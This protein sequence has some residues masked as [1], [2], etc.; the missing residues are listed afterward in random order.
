MILRFIFAIM[1][2][3][4]F[5]LF[6]HYLFRKTFTNETTIKNMIE[7]NNNI[8]DSIYINE[9]T[10]TANFYIADIFKNDYNYT[11]YELTYSRYNNFKT[12]LE[13]DFYN[14]NYDNVII[15]C[16]KNTNY[17]NY[18]YYLV[19]LIIMFNIYTTFKDALVNQSFKL[20]NVSNDIIIKNN[21]L[22]KFDDVI[23]LQT[24]KDDLKQYVD[25]IHNR[26]IY[27]Q[28]GCKIPRGLLFSGPPGTGK[29]LLAKALAGESN[30]T[31]IPVS[32]SDFIEMYVGVGSA[33]IKKLFEVARQNAPSIIFID[34]IDTIGQ[35]RK[36]H[37]T[38]N[39]QGNTLNKLLTE[40]DGFE[41]DDNVFIIAATNIIDQLDPA[42]TRS[43]RFDRKII[44]DKPNKDERAQMF[45]L[46]LNKVSKHSQFQKNIINNII[47]LSEMT[48]GL[49]GADIS[50]IINLAS[51]RSV[52]RITN[53]ISE[54]QDS[55]DQED[56]DSEDQDSEDQE[57]QDSE[58]PD[59][60]DQDSED[61]D[62]EDQETII[63]GITM[64]DIKFSI[65][66]ILVGFEKKERLLNKREK[67]IVAYHEA[68]H[69]L[70]S[71][72]LTD[73]NQPIKVSIIP[74]GE[75]SLGFS[76]QQPDDNKLSTK[77]ELFSKICV[78]YAGRI[79]EQITFNSITTGA[80]DDIEKATKIAYAMVG[81][82]GMYKNSLVN[83]C[84]NKIIS[85]E[86]K[87]NLDKIV[88]TLTNDAYTNTYKILSNNKNY[89]KKIAEF[90]LEHETI[91]KYDIEN[92]LSNDIKNSINITKF[93]Y[94]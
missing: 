24:V 35:N 45:N 89:L 80:Y 52:K 85:D 64:D 28:N 63:N 90:L 12:T 20:N 29:T 6:N 39:E 66:E 18:V 87:N 36:S 4:I 82:Y 51:L 1:F 92:I 93:I 83:I 40:M 13:T 75:A 79:A 70:I 30:T 67:K 81:T 41:T 94:F 91:T 44:F 68:G 31:F 32:G 7:Q 38:H 34:E 10:R 59:S 73:T 50:N 22:T 43:G 48:A 78:L 49:T 74:R 8:F 5:N 33:R 16:I 46:Y 61:Q 58:D 76:Q 3:Y 17:W 37:D 77:E 56:P 71:Y 53:K 57:D 72:M 88:Q 84:D 26:N 11:N 65:D 69:C 55:E 42:L 21:V 47:E 14:N 9:D 54:D 23:G 62:S 27:I 2:Y 60:E 86:T 19:L 25:F 15:E